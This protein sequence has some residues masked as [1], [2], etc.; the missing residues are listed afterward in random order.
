MKNKKNI[1]ITGGAGFIGSHLAKALL[2][3]GDQIIIIDNFN[4]Y[5]DPKIKA[6]RIKRFIGKNKNLKVLK[7]DIKDYKALENIFKKN[8]INKVCHLAAQA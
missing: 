4:Y 5:Y 2:K 3:R 8:K 1:L 6:D 7:A